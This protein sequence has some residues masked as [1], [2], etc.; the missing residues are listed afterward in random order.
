MA[1]VELGYDLPLLLEAL[2]APGIKT[3]KT[4]RTSKTLKSRGLWERL[5]EAS[6]PLPEA[7]GGL[8]I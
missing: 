1:C 7:P 4:L 5:W 8:R 2:E 3:F 6:K